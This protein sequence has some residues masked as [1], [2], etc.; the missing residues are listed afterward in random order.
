[1]MLTLPVGILALVVFQAIR[2]MALAND[3]AHD[4]ANS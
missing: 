3:E 2:R 4:Q 1:M